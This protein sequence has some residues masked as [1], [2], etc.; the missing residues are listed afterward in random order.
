VYDFQGTGVGFGVGTGVAVGR[1]VAVG[2]GM[3]VAVADGS[4]VA[5]GL[6]DARVLGLAVAT[7]SAV[8]GT[9]VVVWLP[10]AATNA[11][12]DRIAMMARTG[13]LPPTPQRVFWRRDGQ[14]G[15]RG[16]VADGVAPGEG[17]VAAVVTSSIAATCAEAYGPTVA[18]RL[19]VLDACEA[20]GVP[21]PPNRCGG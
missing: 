3:A 12:V 5:L 19:V 1:G 2:L 15:R 11:A 6:A 17:I 21:E 16:R 14:R 13:P 9:G 7:A 20:P 4:G 10:Q 18:Q 8:D